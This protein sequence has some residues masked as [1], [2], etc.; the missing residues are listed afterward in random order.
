MRNACLSVCAFLQV[1]G[2]PED[3]LL[4]SVFPGS[5]TAAELFILPETNQSAF[6]SHTEEQLDKARTTHTHTHAY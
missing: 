1:C 2:F 4:V 3:Q 5:P 6:R